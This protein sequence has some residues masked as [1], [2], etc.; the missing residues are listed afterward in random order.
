MAYTLHNNEE[1][2]LQ[3]KADGFSVIR[4][5]P[6]LLLLDLDSEEA[7]QH[8]LRMIVR[9][10][11]FMTVTKVGAWRS[12]SGNRR[13]VALQVDRSLPVGQ[14]MLLQAIL[15]SDLY[16]ELYDLQRVWAKEKDPIVLFKP[17]KKGTFSRPRRADD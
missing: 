9:V 1:A 2:I 12:K 3:A 8:Y 6:N 11:E 7:Y 15:G 5:A 4:T 16:R 17:R 13:H 10:R 14:R